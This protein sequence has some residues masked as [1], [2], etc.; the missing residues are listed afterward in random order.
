MT[1]HPDS[2]RL[3]RFELVLLVAV[4]SL[5]IVII[6]PVVG[7]ASA[8]ARHGT[9]ASHLRRIG[10]AYQMY[11]ADYGAYPEP[12]ALVHSAYLKRP[13]LLSCPEAGS[14]TPAAASYHFRRR[15]P[16]DFTPIAQLAA[17][18][19]ATVLV[20]CDLHLGTRPVVMKPDASPRSDRHYLVLRAGGSVDRVAASERRTFF[21]PTVR[22]TTMPAF[23]GEPGY[24]RAER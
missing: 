17:L 16:P 4:A 14:A 7:S 22:M 6:W 10:R 3:T 19:P 21:L 2:S 15:V 12:A 8:A 24:D 13:R 11:L 20:F 18:H 23:P 5:L 1:L 9:C